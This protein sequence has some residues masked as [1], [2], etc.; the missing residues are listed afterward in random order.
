MVAYN[1]EVNF[2]FP[3]IILVNT[4][5][6]SVPK[7]EPR[8]FSFNAPFGACDACKG[9]GITQKVDVDYLIPDKSKSIAEGGIIYYKNIY[10][11]ENLEWQKFAALLDYYDIDVHKPI[12]DFTKKNWNMYYTVLKIS[13]IINCILE[14]ERK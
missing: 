3:A 11:T 7:L 5:G 13:L 10:G 4:V 14:V 2:I 9:L 8:L 6:F 12:K 1:E